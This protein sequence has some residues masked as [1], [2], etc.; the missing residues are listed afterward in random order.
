MPV[1]YAIDPDARMVR[2]RCA[3]KVTLPEVLDHLQQLR[4]DPVCPDR[5]DVL[6]DLSDADTWPDR[7]QLQTV[8]YELAQVR[9]KLRLDLCAVIATRDVIFGMLR[10]FEAMTQDYFRDI[11]VFRTAAD[12]E[13]W[14]EARRLL[15]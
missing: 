7:T 4:D 5:L 10:M 11:Q 12:A 1:T 2:T 13:T 3:G 6:L 8:T 9:G 15:P 14:L